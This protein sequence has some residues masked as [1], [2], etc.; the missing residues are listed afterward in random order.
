MCDSAVWDALTPHV[1]NSSGG[2]RLAVSVYG[3][4]TVGDYYLKFSDQIFN[5]TEM[6]YVYSSLFA[7]VS[8]SVLIA[9]TPGW[10]D[11]FFAN[12]TVT[13]YR[14]YSTSVRTH[15]PTYLPTHS[16]TVTLSPTTP[17]PTSNPTNSSP[18]M[19]PTTTFTPTEVAARRKLLAD[20]TSQPTTS[21]SPTYSPTTSAPTAPTFFPTDMPTT[22]NASRHPTMVPT[23]TS[24]PT[25]SPTEYFNFT[26]A[27][28][29]VLVPFVGTSLYARSF[30]FYDAPTPSPTLAPTENQDVPTFAPTQYNDTDKPFVE[31]VE[32]ASVSEEGANITLRYGDRLSSTVYI[33]CYALDS[34]VGSSITSYS[35]KTTH[36]AS[37]L[38]VFEPPHSSTLRGLNPSLPPRDSGTSRQGA[39]INHPPP[40]EDGPTVQSHHHTPQNK[41]CSCVTWIQPL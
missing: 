3:L 6:E 39:W 40:A 19:T 10:I 29:D 15:S 33:S 13:L 8:D 20:P 5:S 38:Y 37:Q 36:E 34:S 17:F 32:V 23:M 25:S 16:P 2:T 18:S 1:G 27:V 7:P 12:T 24:Q 11:A 31:F 26:Y 22:A 41:C 4:S 30:A 14:H 21:G 9:T 28:T 35:V